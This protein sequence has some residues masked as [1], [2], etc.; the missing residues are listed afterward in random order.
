MEQS[1][2]GLQQARGSGRALRYRNLGAQF[3][4]IQGEIRKTF[5]ALREISFKGSYSKCMYFQD[6]VKRKACLLVF[7]VSISFLVSCCEL[8]FGV[9]HFFKMD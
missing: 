6:S 4:K 3:L 5:F 8:T 7:M 1:G 2:T 9:F